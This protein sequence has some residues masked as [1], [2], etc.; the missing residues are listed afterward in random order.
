[1]AMEKNLKKEQRNRARYSRKLLE[2]EVAQLHRQLATLNPNSNS[3]T[4]YCNIFL[5]FTIFKRI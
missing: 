3:T 4:P 5:F 2:Q 1:M